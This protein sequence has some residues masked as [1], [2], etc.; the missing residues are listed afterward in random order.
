M[1]HLP[2]NL[3]FG[4]MYIVQSINGKKKPNDNFQ[5]SLHYYYVFTHRC[6]Q[7][8]FL[9]ALS[10]GNQNAIFHKIVIEIA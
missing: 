6:V 10:K 3:I 4:I 8:Q 2:H 5:W 9:F 7:L 1:F